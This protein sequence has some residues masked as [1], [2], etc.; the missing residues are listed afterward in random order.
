LAQAGVLSRGTLRRN[1]EVHLPSK[2]YRYP[3]LPQAAKT[4]AAMRGRQ[5]N[6]T[7]N[8]KNKKVTNETNSVHINSY[9][10]A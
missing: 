3:R 9:N 4:L 1:L 10:Y 5:F 8:N 6:L 7:V 2:P